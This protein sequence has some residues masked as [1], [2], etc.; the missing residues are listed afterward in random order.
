MNI[1][2]DFEKAKTD[3]ENAVSKIVYYTVKDHPDITDSKTK[4]L[5]KDAIEF[6]K[7][8][9]SKE[10]VIGLSRAIEDWKINPV[11]PKELTD[12]G[13]QKSITQAIE[14]YNK[15]PS[16]SSKYSMENVIEYAEDR[17]LKIPKSQVMK[18]QASIED[19]KETVDSLASFIERVGEKQ[20]I[21]GLGW[22]RAEEPVKGQ[23][24]FK[25]QD[26]NDVTR[27]YII[28]RERKDNQEKFYAAYRIDESNKAIPLKTGNN[29]EALKSMTVAY[30]T[31]IAMN[32]VRVEKLKEYAQKNDLNVPEATQQKWHG[33][34]EKGEKPASIEKFIDKFAEKQVE[35][36]PEKDS[37]PQEP[38]IG[39][40]T[41]DFLEEVYKESH[42]MDL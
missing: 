35:A 9:L 20:E 24:L 39:Q 29:A 14:Q 33:L 25:Y 31:G 27:G 5:T 4:E 37:K 15:N 10:E 13:V 19:K 22:Y 36:V 12:D 11:T 42:G 16:I 38:K 21:K 28:E 17:G 34:L 23:P 3:Y 8:W 26:K 30:Y 6:A 7:P 41:A 1:N 18:M 2:E 40:E 32:E